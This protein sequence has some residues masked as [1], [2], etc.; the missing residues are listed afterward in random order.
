M[1]K[2][3]TLVLFL[4]VSTGHA[5]QDIK[6]D[7]TLINPL[8]YKANILPLLKDIEYMLAIDLQG[9]LPIVYTAPRD[10]IARAYCEGE[11]SCSVAAVTDRRTGEIYVI[12][13]LIVNN[14]GA[15][16]VVFHELVHWVQ[17][18][19][20]WWK[21][22]PDCVRWAKQEMHAYKL[23]SVWLVRNGAR[24]FEVPNLLD[25]CR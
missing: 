21:E 16:S 24:A 5:Q 7:K 11:S 10:Q 8:L 17:V 9:E 3:F 2:F 13:G 18:K 1:R 14:L 23:Q 6:M 15:A 12:P 19:Q 4:W 25:Q 20:G 22:D